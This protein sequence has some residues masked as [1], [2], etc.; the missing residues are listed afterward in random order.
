MIFYTHE[1]S[2]FQLVQCK[3]VY[4]Y[5]N[6]HKSPLMPNKNSLRMVG[7]ADRSWVQTSQSLGKK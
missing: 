7:R 6:E 1:L 4:F 2:A 5:Q 3:E